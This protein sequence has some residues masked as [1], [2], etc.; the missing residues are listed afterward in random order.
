MD[1][2]K[3][4]SPWGSLTFCPFPT[5]LNTGADVIMEKKFRHTDTHTHVT[6][7]ILTG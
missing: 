2:C 4:T 7:G 6:Q 3:P 5:Q 1:I